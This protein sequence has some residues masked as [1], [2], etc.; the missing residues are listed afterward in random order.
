[1]TPTQIREANNSFPSAI[2]A[3]YEGAATRIEEL[4]LILTRLRK[5]LYEESEHS[6]AYESENA[7]LWALLQKLLKQIP[8]SSTAYIEIEAALKG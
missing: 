6:A 2:Q 1:M 5:S 7:R 3:T 8:G 4:E